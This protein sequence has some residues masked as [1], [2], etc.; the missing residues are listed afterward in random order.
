MA[1][2]R[3]IWILGIGL[4]VSCKPAQMQ[5]S[6]VTYTGY[7]IS[8]AA[9]ADTAFLDFLMPYREK[10]KKSMDQ[11]VGFSSKGMSRRQPESEIGNF[12]ADAMKEMGGTRFGKKLMRHL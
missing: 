10:M 6:V 9:P 1:L 12:M 2:L 4:L 3:F 11:I 5:P 7:Q 8:R